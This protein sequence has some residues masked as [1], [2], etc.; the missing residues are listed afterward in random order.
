LLLFLSV[1]G[2]KPH[3][4]NH[5]GQSGSA[6]AVAGGLTATNRGVQE[7]R[8]SEARFSWT[9]STAAN[10]MLRRSV[11]IFNE[12]LTIGIVSE[13]VGILPGAGTLILNRLSKQIREHINRVSS[14]R[15]NNLKVL[16]AIQTALLVPSLD[17]RSDTIV[18]LATATFLT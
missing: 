10:R 1:V 12:R 13:A 3:G 11:L 7:K 9:F 17:K 16:H 6:T 14:L 4:R 5:L 15:E 2:V 8:G 18:S